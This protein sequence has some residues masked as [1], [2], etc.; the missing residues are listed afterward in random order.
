M[1]GIPTKVQPLPYSEGVHFLLELNRKLNLVFCD[2]AIERRSIVCLKALL[3]L[4]FK[5]RETTIFLCCETL[6][7]KTS[8]Y[9]RNNL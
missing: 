4:I 9:M 2:I 6:A 8:V 1:T 7:S 5:I 3:P